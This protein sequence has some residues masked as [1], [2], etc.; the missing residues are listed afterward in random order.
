M[1][2][3]LTLL[4]LTIAFNAQAW[5]ER[6]LLQKAA[7]I[8]RLKQTLVLNQKWVPYPSYTDRAGWEKMAGVHKQEILEKGEKALE[9]QWIVVK[10][11]DYLEFEKSGSR[12]IMEAP[13]GANIN[14]LK[15]LVLAELVEGEGRFMNQIVNGV[16]FFCEMSTWVLSAHLPVR[17]LPDVNQPV[18]DLTSGD[19]GSFFAWTYYFFKD[20][21]DQI[22]PVISTRLRQNLQERIL[23]P[24]MERSD[25]WWQAF[26]LRPGGMVN[27]WNPWCNFNVL[28]AFLLLENDPEKLAAAVHRSMV[29]VDQFINYNHEDGACEEGPSYWGHAAGK[30]YDYLEMLRYGTGGQVSIFDKPI[31]KNLGEY[32]AKSYIGNGWVVNFADASAKG[33]GPAGVIYRYGKAV[34]SDIMTGFSSYLVQRAGGKLNVD[35]GRDLF[36]TFENLRTVNDIKSVTPST[37]KGEFAWYPQTEFCYMRQGDF[38]FA[39]KGGYNAESHNHNDIGAFILYYKN[40]PVLIDVGV[41]TYTRQTFS[42]ERYSIWTMQSGY[43]NLPIV[44]GHEQLPGRQYRSKNASFDKMNF[45]LDIAG[46]YGAET[47][48]KSWLKNYKLGASFTMEDRFE[49]TNPQ[50]H[51]EMIFMLAVKPD[52]SESGSV[53]LPV[54]NETLKLQYDT[55]AFDVTFETVAQTDRRLSSVWGDEIYRLRFKAKKLTKKGRYLFTVSN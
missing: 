12:Q 51:N 44:N 20:S 47:G 34:S 41:G 46:A 30:L 48:I 15:D 10:A 4:L 16:W 21:F 32:I 13:F 37:F 36:R 31:I 9:F 24:Y 42:H 43:H 7:D 3:L 50:K 29:S 40:Q 49:L 17:S 8:S 54:G 39:A 38:F 1:K 19:L 18:I 26:N 45:S 33:G 35:G 2:K 22:N 14:A 25:F 52:L 27:N 55:K 53:T 11:T 23:D 28:S 5:E 6:N